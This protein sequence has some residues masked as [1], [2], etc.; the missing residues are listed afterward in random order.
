MSKV[1]AINSNIRIPHTQMEHISEAD[2]EKIDDTAEYDYVL[3]SGG[4]GALRRCTAFLY[5]R[6]M[7]NKVKVIIHKR[8]TFNL[9][10]NMYK[11]KNVRKIAK[12]IEHGEEL[13]VREIDLYSINGK[14]FFIFSAGNS[15]D[16][17]YIHL[18]E[19]FRIGFLRKSKFRYLLSFIFLLPSILILLPITLLNK[20]SFLLFLFF[21]PKIKKFFNIYF[22]VDSIELTPNEPKMLMQLDGD[23]AMIE[24]NKIIIKKESTIKIV[25]G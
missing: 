21:S 5:N 7:L 24:A 15:L 3:I 16:V 19:L 12:K 9:L 13:A 2:L 14:E 8:G 17:L 23:L 10:A 1:L 11:I 18:S 4:D 6:N 22:N 25:L 20:K